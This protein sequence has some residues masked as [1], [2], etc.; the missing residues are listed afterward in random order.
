MTQSS[1]KNDTEVSTMNYSPLRYPGGKCKLAPFITLL[2]KKSNIEHPIYIEPFAGGAGIAL[3]LLFSSVV[4][5]V[6]INDYDKAIYSLWRA[7]LKETEKFISLIKNTPVSIDEWRRQKEIYTTSNRHYSLELGFAA[8]YLNRTNRSGILCNAGPI[9][10]FNQDGN[11]LIDA[12]YNKKNL[13]Q[14]IR[15]IAEY[16]SKIHLYNCDVRSFIE[17]YIPKYIDR[18]F[19]YFDPPYYNKGKAL[20]KNF[21]MTNDHQEIYEMIT[22]LNC[23][24]VVTYD[25]VPEIHQIY[26]Q[27]I[28]K[29]FDLVYSVANNGMNSEIMFLSDVALWPSP[30]EVVHYKININLRDA[31]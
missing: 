16:K 31:K 25:D 18:A 13:I 29:W 6:V 17:H 26:Q 30:D 11:Y 2:I 21:F 8:F 23:P 4:E 22:T 19:I 7:I 12:R 20:Y 28:C 14:R 9:G 1:D 10:G 5:E 27:H 24:W 15:K 3:S